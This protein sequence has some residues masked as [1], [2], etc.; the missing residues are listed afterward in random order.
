VTDGPPGVVIRVAQIGLLKGGVG[1]PDLISIREAAA[2]GIDRIRKPVWSCRGDHLKLDII[3]GQSG[4]WVHFFAPINKPLFQND[5]MDIIV[6]SLD[7]D[8]KEYTSHT[9]P[10]PETDEYAEMIKQYE[11]IWCQKSY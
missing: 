5:P 8:A 1:M 7:L 11:R 4:P 10:L 6:S 9:G 3:D 2:S